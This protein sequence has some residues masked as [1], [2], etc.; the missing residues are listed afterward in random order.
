MRCVLCG[1]GLWGLPYTLNRKEGYSA[2]PWGLCGCGAV[3]VRVCGCGLWG[4]PYTL[5]RKVANT[6]ALWGCAACGS[7]AVGLWGLPYTLNRKPPS[8]LPR[9][10]VGSAL[11][12][13]PQTSNPLPLQNIPYTL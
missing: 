6:A 5:N 1:V 10:A 9:G 13:K 12:P 7:V 8:P 3:V 2:A 4:L 11:H